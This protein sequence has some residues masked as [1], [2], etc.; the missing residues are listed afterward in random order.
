[1]KKKKI[2]IFRDVIIY[3]EYRFDLNKEQC[4]IFFKYIS[5][6]KNDI[7]PAFN[8]D[9]INYLFIKK[10]GMYFV[11]TTV[12]LVSPSFAFEFLNRV[13]TLIQDYTA[14]LTEE[15]IRL[16]FTLIYELLDELLDFGFPQLT[17]TESLKPFV[18]TAPSETKIRDF[19]Q[20]EESLIESIIN[21]T[22]KITIP[23]KSSIKPI[24]QPS[25]GQSQGNST[26]INPATL[27]GNSLISITSKSK[28]VDQ[29]NE[30]Y[31]DVWEHLTVLYA[32]NGSVLRNE[33]NGVIQM[34]SYLKGNPLI[35]LGLTEE[36]NSNTVDDFTFHECI[37]QGFQDGNTLNFQPPQGEFNLL[38]YRISNSNYSPFLINTHLDIQKNRLDLV[39]KLRSNFANK[40]QSNRILITIPVPKSTKSCTHSLDYGNGGGQLVEYHPADQ[41]ITWQIQRMRGSME[42]ILR[43]RVHVDSSTPETLLKKEIGPVGLE[44]DI[45]NLSCSCIQI[46]FLRD[47]NSLIP[48]IRWIRYIA[49]SKSYVSRV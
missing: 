30:I 47:L 33:I 49:E 36:F 31:V 40:I 26:S 11:L 41:N 35:S 42:T 20:K 21:A 13:S 38:R 32:N 14:S 2:K 24:H 6:E 4:D 8:I 46:K 1:M 25:Q 29:T 34:K 12:Q 16:N 45:P 43:V 19:T 10:R 27:I 3:K 15:A 39:V 23:G 48:P 28:S 37:R 44:F 17:S 18:F 5:S 22:T 7:T 9:G